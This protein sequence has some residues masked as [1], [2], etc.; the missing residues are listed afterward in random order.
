M[1][2]MWWRQCSSACHQEN[3]RI[4]KKKVAEYMCGEYDEQF[5][6]SHEFHASVNEWNFVFISQFKFWMTFF[7]SNMLLH[8]SQLTAELR[9]S[10]NADCD[11][12]NFILVI[13]WDIHRES[14]FSMETFNWDSTVRLLNDI[15]ENEN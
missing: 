12:W 7:P 14:W 2:K 4:L 8:C 5:E 11:W 9:M 3:I 15:H 1:R 13:I 6:F 10:S